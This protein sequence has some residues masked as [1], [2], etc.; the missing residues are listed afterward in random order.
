M[1]LSHS[2]VATGATDWTEAGFT[3]TSHNV[4]L[5]KSCHKSFGISN[6]PVLKLFSSQVAALL[7][8]EKHAKSEKIW[9][10]EEKEVI[11]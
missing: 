1:G 9:K 8:S 4:Q 5:N 10:R 6:C 7:P 3:L 2:F 11:V